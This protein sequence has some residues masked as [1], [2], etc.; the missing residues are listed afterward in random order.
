MG[1]AIRDMSEGEIN[2]ISEYIAETKADIACLQESGAWGKWG[3]KIDSLLQAV[4]PYHDYM[5]HPGKSPDHLT[6]YSQYPIVSR[7][8]I[9]Y[10]SGQNFSMAYVLNVEGEH[11]LV[12]NNHFE[13]NKLSYGDKDVFGQMVHGKLS[14]DSAKTESRMLFGKL[15]EALKKRAPQADAVAAYIKKYLDKGMSVIVCGDFNDNPISYTRQKVAEADR[16]LCLSGKWPRFHL[17]PEQYVC[18]HRLYFLL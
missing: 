11:V 7:E 4:Y 16:L 9:P 5:P 18:A 12:V 15:A 14:N 10:D 17:P 13:S 2:Q 6:L 1:Y 8:Q 3:N